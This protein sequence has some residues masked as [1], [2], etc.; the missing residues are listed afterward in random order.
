MNKDVGVD[1][2]IDSDQEVG[3]HVSTYVASAIELMLAHMQL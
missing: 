1:A 2:D 3:G